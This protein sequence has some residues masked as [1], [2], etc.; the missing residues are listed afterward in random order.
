MFPFG[1]GNI[2]KLAMAY[3]F[4]TLYF[5]TPVGTLYLQG[6]GLSYFQINSL[7][8]IIVGTMFLTEVPTG[9][10]ADRLGCKRSINAALALQVLGEVIFVFGDGYW[11][12]ALASVIGGL[13][14]AFGSGS[15]EA[16]V[17]DSLKLKG[18]EDEMSKA[19]GFISA[20][21]RLANLL[22]CALGGLL[23]VKL[24]QER[25]VL[26]IVVTACAVAVG[27]LVSLTLKEPPVEI[28][29]G[30]GDRSL[31]LLLDGIRTLRHDGQFQRLVLLAL[32]TVPFGN[33]LLNLYQPRFVEVGVLPIWLGLA[34]TL[35]SALSVL[36]ARYAYWLEERL[37]PKTGLLLVTS[38]P[39]VLYLVMAAVL[40]PTFAVLTFCTLYG[41]MSL[42]D[43]IFSGHLNRHIESRNRATVLSLISMF[44]GLY[45]SLMGL[46]I[47]RI[48]DFSLTY[49]FVFM[50]AIVLVGSLLFRAK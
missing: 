19:M 10:L 14:F 11:P 5:Y 13:G 45:V 30:D 44:S 50:G 37:D 32:A 28:R 15:I 35:G 40:H 21:Q 29:E 2:T 38:L 6:K 36:G 1:W 16:L 12:F 31:K 8:G 17:Y 41:S 27:W 4:S 7:W 25:F 34:L 3:F 20:A 26:A 47:G 23:A 48:G 46:V 24:T 33:Y 39:G 9:M 43:P 18:R 42:K 49:A 22:A